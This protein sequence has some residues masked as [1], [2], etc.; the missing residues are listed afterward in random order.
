MGEEVEVLVDGD[1]GALQEA[2]RVLAAD[3]YLSTVKGLRVGREPGE[4]SP[5]RRFLN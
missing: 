2:A 1:R 4:T 3:A 5:L